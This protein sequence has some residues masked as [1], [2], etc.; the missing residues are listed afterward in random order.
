MTDTVGVCIEYSH[1][2]CGKINVELK[3]PDRL[4]QFWP[5][6]IYEFAPNP[7]HN[8]PNNG[9]YAIVRAVMQRFTGQ[10]LWVKLQGTNQQ[11]PGVTVYEVAPNKYRVARRF[12]V[13]VTQSVVKTLASQP[14]DIAIKVDN[15]INTPK[16]EPPR[17]QPYKAKR[18]KV[19]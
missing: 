5:Q 1:E 2:S 12:N 4:R 17:T 3:L 19:K 9:I 8:E 15:E 16:S 10:I 18:K 7:A 11:C 13:E 6:G 14:S